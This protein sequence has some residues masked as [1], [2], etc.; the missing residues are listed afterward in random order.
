MKKFINIATALS[1]AAAMASC[2]M[3]ENTPA[4]HDLQDKQRLHDIRNNLPETIRI[5]DPGEFFPTDTKSDLGLPVDIPSDALD[6]GNASTLSNSLYD[7]VQIPI[8]A[9]AHPRWEDTLGDSGIKDIPHSPKSE[10]LLLDRSLHRHHHPASG[11]HDTGTAR[12]P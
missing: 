3:T 12:Q 8:H 1:L 4:R 11:L 10:R 2:S 7:Y 5:F 9:P 6:Y